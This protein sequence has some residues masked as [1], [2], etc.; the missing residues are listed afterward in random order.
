[1]AGALDQ[2]SRRLPVDRDIGDR[3]RHP[4]EKRAQC[5]PRSEKHQ[6]EDYAEDQCP[7]QAFAQ[8]RGTRDRG[9]SGQQLAVTAAENSGG[10]EHQTYSKNYERN[11]HD[12]QKVAQRAGEE[13]ERPAS[14][15]RRD[16]ESVR[17]ATTT[18]I[19]DRCGDDERDEQQLANVVQATL[20]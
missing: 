7:Y 15:Q 19:D 18:K 2:R 6:R 20:A 4:G 9:D 16:R 1:M 14:Q 10:K 3:S 17:Y 13:P 8:Q 12:R 5:S 11:G